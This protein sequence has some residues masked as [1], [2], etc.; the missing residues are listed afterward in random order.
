MSVRITLAILVATLVSC[1]DDETVPQ[2][3]EL[4]CTP[5]TTLCVAD[6]VYVC[7]PTGEITPSKECPTTNGWGCLDGRCQRLDGGDDTGTDDTGTEDTGTEDTGTEDT[8]EDTGPAGWTW[9]VDANDWVGVDLQDDP[10]VK[11]SSGIVGCGDSDILVEDGIDD[12]IY[13]VYT[14]E[15]AWHTAVQGIKYSIPAGAPMRTEF[16]HFPIDKNDGPHV[17]SLHL[18]DP[19][20]LVWQDEMEVPVASTGW[21]NGEWT[22]EKEW[23]AGTKIWWNLA[24]HGTNEWSLVSVE[25]E[26]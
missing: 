1:G 16:F 24:N 19:P 17:L 2:Q 7:Q 4:P 26:R 9:L 15:C 6:S 21:F 10:F 18:G 14:T 13:S 3:A 8:G 11:D 20:E 5:Y 23:P 22:S 12:K 25:V